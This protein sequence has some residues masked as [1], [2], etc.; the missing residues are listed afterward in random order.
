[1]SVPALAAGLAF[2]S[3]RNAAAARPIRYALGAALLLNEVV[4]Y[5]YQIQHGYLRFPGQLPLQLCDLA[6]WLVAISALRRSAWAL[7]LVWYWGLAGAGMAILT[8]DLWTPFPSYLAIAFFLSHGGVVATILYLVWSR[9]AR[10]RPGSFWRSWLALN[11]IAAV[12]GIF[13][14][15][16]KTNYLYLCQKPG[17]PS[18][19]D[20]LGPWP[21]YIILV[22][23]LVLCFFWLLWLPFRAGR[24]RSLVAANKQE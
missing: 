24:P 17:N 10:P 14:A 22:E 2:I 13:N 9:E 18:L 23:P 3:R 16:F 11:G 4:W 21:L 6:V 5:V 20:L 19:L 1:M 15:V 12:V 7:D 8:P